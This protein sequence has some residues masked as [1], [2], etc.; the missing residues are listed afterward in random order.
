MIDTENRLI[1][2][3]LNINFVITY[4]LKHRIEHIM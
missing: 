4:V 2:Y 1:K 3:I